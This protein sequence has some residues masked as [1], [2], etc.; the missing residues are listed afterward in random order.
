MTEYVR[1]LRGRVGHARVPLVYASTVVAD[2]RG[3]ILFQ[4]RADFGDAW[5]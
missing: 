3:A 5:W 1:W 4:R 2:A